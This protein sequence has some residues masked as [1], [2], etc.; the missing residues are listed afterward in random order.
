MERVY[1]PKK[2]MII[3]S[4]QASKLVEHGCLSYLDHNR[5]V[6]I[7]SLYIESIPVVFEFS[8]LFPN[9]LSGTPPDRDIQ[10]CIDL[11]PGAGPI[12][13]SPWL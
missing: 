11:E 8:E 12:S 7:E 2:A 13:I 4:I 10:F 5:D 1:K 9:H 3:S 6:E